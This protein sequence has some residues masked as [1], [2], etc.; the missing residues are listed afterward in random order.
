[1]TESDNEL[2]RRFARG[3]S[4]TAFAELVTRH[5]GLVYSA[6]L[7]QVDGDSAA[8]ED[9]TQAVF[10]DL[11]RKA[12]RLNGHTSLTGWLYTGTRHLAANVRRADQRRRHREQE[13]HTMNQLLHEAGPEL[14]WNELQPVLDEAMHELNGADREAVLLRYF[15]RRP[16][17]EVGA[18]LGLGENAARMRV[19]RALDKLRQA[20]ARKG[21]T[22]VAA[23][24]SAALAQNAV[25]NAPLGLAPQVSSAAVASA[26]TGGGLILTLIAFMTRNQIKALVG[27]AALGLLVAPVAY[28]R[29]SSNRDSSLTHRANPGPAVPVASAALVTNPADTNGDAA[30][31]APPIDESLR[32]LQLTIITADN[33]LPVPGVLVERGWVTDASFFSQRNGTVQIT[34]PKTAKDLRLTTRAEGFADTCLKWSLER[35]EVVPDTYNLRLERAVSIG[36]SVVDAD[37]KPVGGAKIGFGYQ[38]D[39]ATAGKVE[40][41]EF[42]YIEVSSDEEGR[43]HLNRIANDM[44]RRFGCAAHHP[45]HLEARV[46]VGSDPAAEKAM[47]AGTYVFHLGRAVA[48][49]G[50]VVDV[51]DK[52]VPDAKVLCGHVGETGSREG[53]SNKDGTFT[54]LGCRPGKQLL[55]AQAKGYATTTLEVEVAQDSA[56]V[57]LVLRRGSM[58]RLRVARQDGHGAFLNQ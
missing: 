50:T 33:G 45:D 17:A 40:S 2:L 43:W 27:M 55:S 53:K 49:T 37:G 56:P 35:G 16:L 21:V 3:R 29:L 31:T 30:L 47:R 44:F 19:E 25:A 9:V 10:T 32:R 1:M 42:G 58:L 36:G 8:A 5:I 34:F 13:A 38:G 7:R 18:R 39:P 6:A 20:L 15:E 52:P 14:D 51:D 4:E 12:S 26:A 28:S 11:A 54:L 46:E 22:S 23:A 24:L 48:V 41:H 57:R